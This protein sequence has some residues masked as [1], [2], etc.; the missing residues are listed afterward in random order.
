MISIQE[1]N[2]LDYLSNVWPLVNE[3]NNTLKNLQDS[4]KNKFS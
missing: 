2:S 4:D 3:K 1:N